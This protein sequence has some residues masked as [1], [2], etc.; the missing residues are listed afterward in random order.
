MTAPSGVAR[1][2][3]ISRISPIIFLLLGMLFTSFSL[4]FLVPRLAQAMLQPGAW[5]RDTSRAEVYSPQ[6]PS[7]VSF[8]AADILYPLLAGSALSTPGAGA[9]LSLNH[10]PLF[11]I[12][13]IKSIVS[14]GQAA[15]R[16]TLQYELIRS[17]RT[18]RK[19]D[20]IS[21]PEKAGA[22]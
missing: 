15:L 3:A 2:L 7:S 9:W 21:R 10:I 11:Q 6:A 12:D 5:Q 4:L 16:E 19:R 17:W 13:V 8:R 20:K 14:P 22:A 18:R 1:K